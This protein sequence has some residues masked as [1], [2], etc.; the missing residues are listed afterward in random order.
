MSLLLSDCDGGDKEEVIVITKGNLMKD[1][2]DG[3]GRHKGFPEFLFSI[4]PAFA[5]ELSS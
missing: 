5:D 1:E 4:T 2:P 3:D